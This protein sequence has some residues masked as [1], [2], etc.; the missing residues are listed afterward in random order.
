VEINYA[1]GRVVKD[2]DSDGRDF[3]IDAT[4]ATKSIP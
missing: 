4:L 2:E 3:S 1:D